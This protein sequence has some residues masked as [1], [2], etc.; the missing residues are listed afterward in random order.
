MAIAVRQEIA[1]G[2]DK[3]RARDCVRVIAAA[4]GVLGLGAQYAA[5]AG[6]T[7]SGIETT[8][9]FLCYFTY[10]TNAIAALSMLLPVWLPDS[11]LGRF[12]SRPAVRTAIAANL[13]IAGVVYHVVLREPFELTWISQAD[14]CL[15]YITPLVYLADWFFSVPR[16]RLPWH[17]ATYSVAVPGA[18][19]VW[20]F[21]YGAVT[22]WYPYPFIEVST[23]GAVETLLNLFCLLSVFLIATAML[24]LVDRVLPGGLKPLMILL[25]HALTLRA[26]S[27]R[28]QR[29]PIKLL[30]KPSRRL[31]LMKRAVTVWNGNR[32]SVSTQ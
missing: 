2:S 12:L 18:Y 13:V 15:H 8:C 6:S 11:M 14:F 24:I 17:T 4:I 29:R 31:S 3:R 23:L 21:G 25:S 10:W 30:W 28:T 1:V 7:V 20:M 27:L 19:G 32:A 22:H 16:T 9:R 5:L 26:P